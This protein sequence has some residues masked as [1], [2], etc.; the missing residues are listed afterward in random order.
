MTLVQLR[1][2]IALAQAGSFSRAA[3]Q[4]F[5]TQPALSRSIRSL[6]DE[7]GQRL[8]DRIGWKSELTPAGHEVLERARRLVADAEHLKESAQQ[9]Q[10]G[11]AG[12]VRL[13]LGS[14]PGAILAAPVLRYMAT[15]HPRAHIEVARGSTALLEQAL[16]ERQL[17][18]LVVDARSVPPSP[19]LQVEGLGELRGAFLCRPGHPLLARR[20]PLR[21]ADL[22]AYPVASTPLSAEIG[23]ILVERYGP[24]AH[25]PDV[26]TL[27]SEDIATL[28]Q[29]VRASDAVLL[30]V[31]AA[32]PS[33]EELVLRPALHATARFGLVTLA[34][35]SQ[36]PLLAAL[37]PLIGSLL[38]EQA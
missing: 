25:L 27:G 26:V 17:D 9:L 13:G 33:L 36:P 12:R 6:E 11:Q 1:H 10:A 18:A 32:A 4:L 30:A 5:L 31:R 21:F 19:E 14:G 3:E 23:R 15:H 38:Q 28:E 7:L 20:A 22:L 2:L 29:V 16:R 24:S 34:G 8:F 35:R 37:R